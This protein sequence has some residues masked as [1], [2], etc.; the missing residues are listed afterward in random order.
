M[1][2]A[3]RESH[4]SEGE[5]DRLSESIYDLGVQIGRLTATQHHTTEV[6]EK[7]S[8]QVTSIKDR[9]LKQD[10]ILALICKVWKFSPYI[11]SAVFL[12]TLT[13]TDASFNMSKFLEKKFINFINN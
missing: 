1:S 8:D 10:T 4:N 2:H 13:F 11:L 6:I 12:L 3:K 7:L 5:I 9:N